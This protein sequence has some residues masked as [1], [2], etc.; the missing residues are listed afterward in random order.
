[1]EDAP[2]VT[3]NWSFKDNQK[4]WAF[5]VLVVV[6]AA[7]AIYGSGLGSKDNNMSEAQMMLTNARL[8]MVDGAIVGLIGI[9]GMAAQSLFRTSETEKKNAEALQQLS[10]KVP[11]PTDP[12]GEPLGRAQPV[13]L[14]AA[15]PLDDE[16]VLPHGITKEAP[17]WQQPTT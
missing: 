4:F 8:R 14:G 13:D 12:S 15:Q 9:A 3:S 16:P 1:M 11:P 10:Q 7:L 2:L 6:I 5:V 17:S